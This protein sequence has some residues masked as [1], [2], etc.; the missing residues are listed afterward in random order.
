M[1][2]MKTLNEPYSKLAMRRRYEVWFLRL[3]LADGSG[4]WWFRYLLLNPGRG[5]CAENSQG[6]PAQVWATWFPREGKPQSWIQGFPLKEL[7][8]SPCNADPFLLEMG[9]NRISENEC[10][11]AL[12]IDG[13]R[14][15]WDLRYRSSFHVNLSSMG[16]I[17]FSR[18]PH[19]DARFSGQISLDGR[20]FQGE[21][22]GYGMQ[23]HNCGYRHRNFWTWT[24][25]HFPGAANGGSTFE[26]LVYEMPV[27]LFFH[28]AV[29]WHN[30]QVYTFR[31]LREEVRDPRELV[32]RLRASGRADVHVEV[33]IRGR[34]DFAHHLP[35][36]KTDCSG[37]FEVANDSLAQA[38]MVLQLPG[39]TAEELTTDTGAALEMV[40]NGLSK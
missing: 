21:P 5:G 16:W 18:T 15:T 8:L 22:L 38:R 27:G 30:A 35:Y 3:G 14:I 40:G 7:R 10:R 37:Q 11:G 12:Q 34:K 19:S 32:W 26:A 23:G 28:R 17:G 2:W 9:E 31:S 24:H 25:L 29:L 36:L 33:D 1:T 39:R 13:R 6:Y 4:A 20:A